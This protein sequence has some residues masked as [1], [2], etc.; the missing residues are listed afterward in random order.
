MADAKLAKYA[1]AKGRRKNAVATIRLFSGKGQ[2][3][4]NDKTFE[5]RY[6]GKSDQKYILEPFAVLG[7]AGSFYFTAKTVGGGVR[8]QA[9][10]IRHALSRALLLV[11]PTF[12]GEL[13]KHGFLTRDPRMVERK[14]TGLRKARKAEQYSKR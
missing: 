5:E 12:R 3:S 13:K 7:K 9:G 4:V 1:Y 10:A 14:K 8:G 6:P 2:S 11:D